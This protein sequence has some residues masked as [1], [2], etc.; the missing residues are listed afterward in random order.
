[1]KKHETE[2]KKKKEAIPDKVETPV[3][4]WKNL[5]DELEGKA[6]ALRILGKSS[7]DPYYEHTQKNRP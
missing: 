3:M 5:H 4:K 7:H 6:N 1:M 2:S